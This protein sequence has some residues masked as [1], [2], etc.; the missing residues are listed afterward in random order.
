MFLSRLCPATHALAF[1]LLLTP[2]ALAQAI[3]LIDPPGITLPINPGG[4]GP[5]Q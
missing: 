4:G 5:G 2:D 1:A 3:R